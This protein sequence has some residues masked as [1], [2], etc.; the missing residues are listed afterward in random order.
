MLF[1]LTILLLQAATPLQALTSAEQAHN[2][3]ATQ[4][5]LIRLADTLPS[6]TPEMTRAALPPILKAIAD[7]DPQ[8]RTLAMLAVISIPEA[9]H[10]TLN[11]EAATIAAHL[12]D[13]EPS[14]RSLTVLAL[15]AFTP[16]PPAPVIPALLKAFDQPDPAL[17]SAIVPALL[18]LDVDTH[19]ESVD[20]ILAFLHRTNLPANSLPKLIATIAHAKK[21]SARLDTGLLAFLPAPNPQPVRSA[22]IAAL[23]SLRLNPAQLNATRAQL[24]HLT[25]DATEDASLK[26]TAAGILPCWHMPRMTDPCPALPIRYRMVSPPEPMAKPRYQ[27]PPLRKDPTS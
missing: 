16:H 9:N 27:S 2:A 6:A 21:H 17:G 26:S 18:S 25:E 1:A 23:P 15:G 14:V 20:A 22:L 3:A 5:S 8:T 11:P 13:P 24:T 19:P 10:A 4:S 7:P 12:T